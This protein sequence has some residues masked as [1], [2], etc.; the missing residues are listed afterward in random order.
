MKKCAEVGVDLWSTYVERREAAIQNDAD[1]I[2]IQRAHEQYDEDLYT[3]YEKKKI[4]AMVKPLLKQLTV[5]FLPAEKMI[6]GC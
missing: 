3:N 5:D 6:C 2:T 1:I 4:A